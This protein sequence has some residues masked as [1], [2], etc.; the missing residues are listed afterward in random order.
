MVHDIGMNKKVKENKQADHQLNCIDHV[1]NNALKSALA[2][3]DVAPLAQTVTE[4]AEGFHRSVKQTSIL[5]RTCEKECIEYKKIWKPNVTRWNSLC[6][7]IEAITELAPAFSKLFGSG[8]I[9]GDFQDK[10]PTEATLTALKQMLKPLQLIKDW[11]AELQAENRPTAQLVIPALVQ[12]CNLTK[13]PVYRVKTTS[14][15]TQTFCKLFEQKLRKRIDDYGRTM[16]Q[17]AIANFLHP[18]FKGRA[19][20]KENNMMYLPQ[21]K[22]WIIKKHTR[23]P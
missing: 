23:H 10:L 8:E 6:R 11:T 5:C 13:T 4:L 1:I 9:T 15:T 14:K 19:L 2:H 18:R 22:R 12:L 17:L 20:N 21:T 16:P 3:E 7:T